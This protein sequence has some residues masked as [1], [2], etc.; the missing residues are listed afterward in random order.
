MTL[1]PGENFQLPRCKGVPACHVHCLPM[2]RSVLPALL[3][4][5]VL[6]FSALQVRA[7]E[8]GKQMAE[9]ANL[10][11]SVL[12]PEQKTKAT[13]KFDDEERINWHFIPRERKGLPL[14]EMTPQQELLAHALLNTGLGFRGAAK[15]ATIMSLEEVLWQMEG[16]KAADETAKAAVRAKRD[17]EQYF[18]SIFGTPDAKGTWGWRIEGHHLSLNFTIKDGQLL[19]ASPTFFGTNPGEVR[20]GNLSGLRVLGKEEDLGRELVKSLND[21]QWKKS[22]FDAVA[23]KEMITA[24][25]KR[26]NPLKPEG[27]SN[28]D[29]TSEQ[30]AKLKEII[31]EYTDRVR[32]EIA[33]ELW[34]EIE[35]SPITFA[36]AGGKER[37]EPHYYRVQG[38]TFLI[39]YDNVQGEAN[40][41][42]SVFRSFEGDFGRDVLAEHHKEA[43]GK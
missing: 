29:M 11:L 41:P 15:A 1:A 17:P 9:V 21:E 13:F 37:G 10:F 20:Q 23:P 34:A 25:E 19:R 12:T 2:I 26:V 42:H 35:K 31:T 22:L 16:A 33:A 43:H 6:A 8:A 39:E 4:T 7:H 3:C 40:H 27:L 30:K 24:A 38:A 32:P 28:A 36:W 14:K 18:V 5:S